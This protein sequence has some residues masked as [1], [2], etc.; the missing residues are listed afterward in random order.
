[1]IIELLTVG[2]ILYAGYAS[3]RAYQQR[4]RRNSFPPWLAKQTRHSFGHAQIE[5]EEIQTLEGSIHPAIKAANRSILITSTS[6]VLAIAGILTQPILRLASLLLLF[7]TFTPRFRLAYQDLRQDRRISPSV[8]QATRAAACLALGYLFAAALDA[9]LEALTNKLLTRSKVSFQQNLTK[10][11]GKEQTSEWVFVQGV[12]IETAHTDIVPGDIIAMN[13]GDTVPADGIIVYGTAWL[14]EHLKRGQPEPVLKRVGES[15]FASTMVLGGQ[16]YIQVEEP[17]NQ[18]LAKQVRHSLQKTIQT[19]TLIQQ[20]GERSGKRIAPYSFILFAASLPFRGAN[21]S[22]AFLA[23]GF[24]AQMSALGPHILYNF[25]DLA[26]R[27]GI[28]IKDGRVLEIANLINTIVVDA[29]VLADPTTHA[30]AKESFEKLRNRYWPIHDAIPHEFAI[31]LISDENEETTQ[32]LAA[33]LAVDDYFIEPLMMTKATV[34]ESLQMGGRFIC[35]VGNGVT[36]AIVMKKAL[37]SI[38]V[39][40]T[41]TIETN[42]AQIVL[43]DK[44]LGQLDQ[45]F[46]L[47]AQFGSKQGFNVVWPLLMDLISF[48]TTVFMNLGIVYSLL[49]NYSGMLVSALNTRLPLI[50]YENAKESAHAQ[51]AL[52]QKAK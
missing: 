23:P 41:E 36:D 45:I 37:I 33:E 10:I 24:G 27:Q 16:I 18:Q 31:Y 1:M 4:A 2:S 47:V 26:A 49:F 21:R 52:V 40:N 15:V 13:S 8:L 44:D 29:H 7:Y 12:E 22:I 6:L 30:K 43:V 34:L 35:Y 3:V 51:N 48:G 17:T 39:Q 25:V 46:E 32:K 9:W 11:V 38:A 5:V 28:F 19:Q 42:A 14:D 50:Q 20:A